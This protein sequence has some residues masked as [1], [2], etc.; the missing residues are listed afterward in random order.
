MQPLTKARLAKLVQ[1]LCLLPPWPRGPAQ[2]TVGANIANW[3]VLYLLMTD[4]PS[5]RILRNDGQTYDGM[6]F[7]AVL[8]CA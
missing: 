7:M 6:V 5:P 3:L 1:P 8:F 2:A 4:I